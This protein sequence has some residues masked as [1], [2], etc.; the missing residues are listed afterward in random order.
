ML[1]LQRGEGEVPVYPYSS[2]GAFPINHWD[3][4]PSK[5]SAEWS[6]LERGLHA[7]RVPRG[8]Y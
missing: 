4:I 1:R 7:V 5:I 2:V 8:Q 6:G 3:G